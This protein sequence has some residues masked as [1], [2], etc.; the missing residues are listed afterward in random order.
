MGKS[1]SGEGALL[2]GNKVAG[3]DKMLLDKLS[4]FYMT[5]NV[6]A[7]Y[8]VWKG[9]SWSITFFDRLKNKKFEDS[10]VTQTAEQY[11]VSKPRTCK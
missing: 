7:L 3:F 1:P 10:I 11:H 4:F 5:G 6:F 9:F 2:I 8:A